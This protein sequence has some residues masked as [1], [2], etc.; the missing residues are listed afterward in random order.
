MSLQQSPT[1]TVERPDVHNGSQMR[2]R[3]RWL[4]VARAG[5]VVLTLLVLAL[6]AIAIPRAVTL[7]QAVCQPGA[8]CIS[9]LTPTDLRQLQQLGL[10]P[11]FLAAYQIGWDVGTTVIYTTLAALIFWRRS[12][13]RMAL[14]C[15]YML[16]LFGG[17]TYTGLLDVGLRTVAPAWYWLVGGLELLAQVCVPTFFLLFPSGRFV[18]RWTRWGVLVFVLDE[19]WYV[20]LS[21]AYLGQLSGVISLV[22]AAL[23]LGL[24]GLQIYRYRRVSI[25]RERQQ[26]KWVVFGLAVALGGFALFLIVVNLFLPP[27]LRNSPVARALIPTT[28]S[29]GLLLFIPISIAIA[30]LRSRLY[31]I[32]TIINKALV[33]GLL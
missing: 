10:S 8:L 23:I 20:F 14:F 13:D 1:S 9:G 18:P 31:D 26:T 25:V 16:V 3:G 2:L 24:V 27:D 17:A 32:D 28:V 15:A 12:V 29:D 6:N 30:I 21:N 22:F 7:L 4:F 19:V 33:Y 5:W 11:G